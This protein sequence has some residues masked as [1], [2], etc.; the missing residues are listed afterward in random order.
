MRLRPFLPS[1]LSLYLRTKLWQRASSLAWS[2][3]RLG[4]V[5]QVTDLLIAACALEAEAAVLTCDS[6]FAGVPGWRALR[7]LD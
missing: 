7:S 2:L 3:D 4:K 1:S 5:M 6:D